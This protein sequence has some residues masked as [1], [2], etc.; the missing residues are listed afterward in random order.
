MIKLLSQTR[1]FIISLILSLF[2]SVAIAQTI[3]IATGEYPPFCS[4]SA[5]HYGFVSHV[6]SEA[7][8]R[9]G[10]QVEFDFLP[11]KRA[12]Y[13]TSNGE[14][15]ATSWWVYSDERAA[16]FYYS[17]TVVTNSVHFF[18]VKAHNFDFDWKTL[19]DLDDY[20]LGVTRGYFYNEEFTQ[21]REENTDR[22]DVV[23][24]DEQ[25]LKRMLLKRIDLFP[26]NVV[27]GLELLRTKFGPNVIHQITYHPRPLSSKDGFILFPKSQANSAQLSAIFNSG[28]KKLKA[29]GSYE[30]MQEN[31]LSGYYSN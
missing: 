10:H 9:E 25:S 31:L 12:L 26:V 4:S 2:S 22:F 18:Y 29:D 3:R 13:Q 7:F 14:Y 24:S 20:R 15:D 16:K 11:W 27:V 8:A 19:S 23:N 17:D 6:I 1:I 28:L 21:Y 30:R 5:K